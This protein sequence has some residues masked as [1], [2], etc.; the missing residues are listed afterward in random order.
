MAPSPYERTTDQYSDFEDQA[1]VAFSNTAQAQGT[2]NRLVEQ[3]RDAG[4]GMQEVA[5]NM[6]SALDKSLHD[7]PCPRWRWLP[8]QAFSSERAGRREPLGPKRK[9]QHFSGAICNV[10]VQLFVGNGTHLGSKGREAV[11][12]ARNGLGMSDPCI[13]AIGL[14]STT[15]PLHRKNDRNSAQDGSKAPRAALASRRSVVPCYYFHV[16]RG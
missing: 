15:S 1:T 9:A 13:A 6:K 12:C 8:L 7:Q 5:G 2:T 11:A 16:R 14:P 3:A 10:A 4:A